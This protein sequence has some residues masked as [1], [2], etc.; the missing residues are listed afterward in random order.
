[1]LLTAN[2]LTKRYSGV[3]ALSQAQFDLRSGEVHALVGENGAGKSTLCRILCGITQ[4]D[5]GTMTLAGKPHAP[6]TRRE[7]EHAGVR[8]VMQELN[9]LPTLTVAENIF[10]DSMPRRLGVVRY[11]KMNDAT[12]RA[13]DAV[14]LTNVRPNQLVAALGVGQQQLVEIAAALSRKCQVLVLDEPTA[15]LTAPEIELLF[16]QIRKLKSAGVGI[17]YVSHRME[18]IRDISDRIT[19]LRDGK[20]I[21]TRKTSEITH[22]ETVR[23]MVGRDISQTVAREKSSQDAPGEVALSVRHLSSGIV[24]D[25][26]FDARRGEIFGFAGLMGSGRTETMRAVFGAD[27]KEAGEVWVRGPR[28]K[29]RGLAPVNL[30]SPRDAVRHGIALLT[31]DRKS[32]GLLLPLEIDV[33]TSL[34]RMGAVAR[35]K[36]WIDRRRERDVAEGYIQ[37]LSIRCR[38]SR[39]RAAEL[40]GGNQQK[41]VLAKWLLRDC[42]VLIFDEPTRG[43]DVGAK[44]E[45]YHLLADLARKGKAIIVVSSDLLELTAIAD[46]I[47]VMSAGRLAKIFARG[48][49]TQELIMEAALSGYQNRSAESA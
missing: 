31:E 35:L 37:A 36:T 30:R 14:G 48:Q 19:V 34:P 24:H 17:I 26:S 32:Q 6:R 22:E 46:R 2:N 39:Q 4:P 28:A 47:A 8:M 42:D 33:N 18:E 7:A 13:I 27:R 12:Q 5:E 45:I 49:W 9:L 25:V 20:W 44:F 10:I 40:S 11:R 38:S 1:M 29:A 16:A 23:L 43:I 21:A 3:P 15:A 41:I